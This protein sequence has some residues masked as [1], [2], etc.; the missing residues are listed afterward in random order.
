M[1]KRGKV[2]ELHK[3]NFAF[4]GLLKCGSCGA[5]ITAEKQKDHHYY[6]RCIKKKGL[7]QEKHYLREEVL[8][9]QIIFYLQ[10][11]SLS[12]QD[13]EKVLSAL[14]SEQDKARE[15]AQNEVSV[16][17]EQ[18]S[19]VEVKLQNLLDIYLA[20]ALST[21][22]YAAKKTEFAFPKIRSREENH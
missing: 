22:E 12:S 3:N 18:L 13:T 8:I 21:E 16:L 6:Y 2:H 5:S 4:L 14:D 9:E 7:C 11:V 15:E 19:R 10:K 1:A 20:D 17:K